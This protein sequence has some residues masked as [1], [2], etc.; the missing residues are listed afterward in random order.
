M[1]ALP[2]DDACTRPCLAML[3]VAGPLLSESFIA[4][5]VQASESRLHSNHL[6]RQPQNDR[7]VSA[8]F[9]IGF[10][11][12]SEGASGRFLFSD[13]SADT[14]VTHVGNIRRG[15]RSVS[16]IRRSSF[17]VGLQW[18]R[19]LPR[20]KANAPRAWS[21]TN[22]LSLRSSASMS[23]GLTYSASLSAMRCEREIRPM[24]RT[25]VPPSFLALSAIAS[26]ME[27][28]CSP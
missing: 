26:V 17:P 11:G 20:H 13:L 25:V 27:K 4:L 3:T 10:R 22:A 15:T 24:E 23:S 16:R 12:L 1:A 8:N 28:S 19:P 7:A 2:C 5:R 21:L 18:Q 9:A 6:T 14:R